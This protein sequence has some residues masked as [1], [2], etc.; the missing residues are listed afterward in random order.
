MTYT[1][2]Y[3]PGTA[4]MAVHWALIE[5][6]V[7]FEAIGLDFD[8]AEQRNPAYLRLNPSGRVP[9]L[10]IDGRPY[11]ES[12]ALVMLLAERHPDAG[13]APPPGDPQRARW[14]ETMVFLANTV[15]PAM[16]DWFYADKDG[17]PAGAD[18]VRE[19]ARS[20][21]EGAW[22]RLAAALSDGRPFL[23]GDA[24]GAADYL[25]AMLMRWSRNMARPASEHPELA[26]YLARMGALGSYA[27][28]CRREALTPWP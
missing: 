7:P 11:S 6:G 9:T 1:L 13:L 24:P 10:V 26:A 8:A 17:A 15:S 18:A 27:E 4:S 12:A 22:P 2:Y 14:L 19:L 5:L 21:I 16:R 23:F 25:A 28:L 20:R 3:S